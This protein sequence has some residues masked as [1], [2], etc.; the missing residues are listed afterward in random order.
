MISCL[1]PAYNEEKYIKDVIEVVKNCDFVDEIIVIS[2]GSTDK[3]AEIAEAL[4]IK[5]IK[6]EKNLGKGGAINEGLKYAQGNI[7]LLVDADLRGLNRENLY[8]LIKPVLQNKVEMT[9]G[10]G[11]TFVA[12][13]FSGLRAI[14]RFVLEDKNF[15]EKLK[16]SDYNVENLLNDRIKQLNLKSKYIKMKGVKNVHK[17]KKYGFKHG[18]K[19]T[20][21]MYSELFLYLLKK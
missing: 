12:N 10:A 6:L 13:K 14:K 15:L 3:T 7:I 4:G 18:L 20:L 16:N 8:K 17:I 9:V 5:V 11:I 2:D 19:R 21:R 1:I